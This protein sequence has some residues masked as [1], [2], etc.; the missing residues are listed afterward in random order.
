MN[1][2]QTISPGAAIPEGYFDQDNIVFIQQKIIEVLLREYAQRIIVSHGDIIRIMERVLADR[3]ENIPSMNQRVIMTICNDF[4]DH[5]I[6]TNRNYAWEDGYTH[7]QLLIDPFG[8]VSR[9]DKQ[10]I[11]LKDQKK[12]DGKERVGGTSRFYFT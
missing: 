4:R 12:F 2:I 3:R 7:S 10:T 8:A 6:E 11:K 9:F 1:V 5:Q